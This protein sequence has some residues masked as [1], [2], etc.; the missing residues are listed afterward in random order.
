[1]V[2]AGNLSNRCQIRSRSTG[3]PTSLNACRTYVASSTS[4]SQR[5]RRFSPLLPQTFLSHPVTVLWTY[6]V[7]LDILGVDWSRPHR[8][9]I[10]GRHCAV[11]IE[12]L[13]KEAKPSKANAKGTRH[14][15][16]YL[17]QQPL[18]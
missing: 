2:G 5:K 14:V 12:M 17:Q 9:R 8:F 11:F 16:V 6:A 13:L 10:M 3:A 4:E 7:V 15:F 1:M 18:R